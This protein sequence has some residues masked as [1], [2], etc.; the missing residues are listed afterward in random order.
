[1]ANNIYVDDFIHWPNFINV[2]KS[3]THAWL[4]T[5]AQ[6]ISAMQYI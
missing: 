1:M 3:F 4:I 6:Q 2:I 5:F